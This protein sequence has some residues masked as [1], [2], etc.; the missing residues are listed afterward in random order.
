GAVVWYPPGRFPMPFT[1]ILRLVPDYARI[2]LT[3]PSGLFT[4]WR[5]QRVL[6]RL[7]PKEPHCHVCFLGG[8]QGEQVGSALM[9]RVF[10][11][12]EAQRVPIYLETQVCRLT[13]LYAGLGFKILADG[14][15]TL[16]GGPV[17][18]TMWREPRA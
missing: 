8:R 7:R 16:P 9:Q 2:A 18:W 3:S 13:H 15:E 14:V 17:T 1:R 4:L 11:E 6:N 5:A 12:A 10:D